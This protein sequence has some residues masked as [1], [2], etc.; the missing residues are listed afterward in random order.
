MQTYDLT[1]RMFRFARDIRCLVNSLP[2][3]TTNF[4]DGR[5]VVRSSGSVGANYIEASEP[6]GFKDELHKLKISRK[7]VKETIYWL[8]LIMSQNNIELLTDISKLIDE[9]T[10]ILKILSTIIKKLQD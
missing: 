7:E 5:Q 2:K 3:K 4:E 10:Q 1:E 8:K 9:A 6:L